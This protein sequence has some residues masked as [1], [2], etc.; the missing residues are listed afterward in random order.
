MGIFEGMPDFDFMEAGESGHLMSSTH[1][2]R[3]ERGE[4]R[5]TSSAKARPEISGEALQ[6]VILGGYA[7]PTF[8]SQLRF[9]FDIKS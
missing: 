3:C 9:L 1:L 8:T 7:I 6:R 2:P 5:H 4:G